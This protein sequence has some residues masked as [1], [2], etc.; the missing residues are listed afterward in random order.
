MLVLQSGA[1]WVALPMFIPWF[2]IM[3]FLGQYEHALD[4]KQRL[5]IPAELREVM[6]PSTHG[7]AF[8]GAPG[9]NGALWLWPELTFE[10]LGSRLGGTLLSDEDMM[11]FERFIFSQSARL[12]IDAAGR[13]RIPERHLQRHGLS[14]SVMILGVRDHIELCPPKQWNDERARLEPTSLEVWR[15]ARAAMNNKGIP[16]G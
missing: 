12:P 5:A 14:G 11:A 13:V 10:S 1:K 8:I 9:P 3:L 6:E 2:L 16:G 15:K 7:V 4:T